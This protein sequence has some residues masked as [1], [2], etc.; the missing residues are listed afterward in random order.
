MDL[1]TITG[2]LLGAACVG[3][4]LVLG[5]SF[6]A[7]VDPVALLIV[8]GG[9]GAA[10]L[11]SAPIRRIFGAHKVSLKA[12]MH[13][14]VSPQEQI[15]RLVNLSEL[16]RREGVLALE[17]ALNEIDDSFLVRGVQLAIDG[18]DP[19]T[20]RSVLETEL[21]VLVERHEAGRS[22]FEQL[23]KYAPAFGMIGTVIGLVAMLANMEDPS[24]IGAGMA[25]ALLTTLYG[26][27]L[28]NLVFL[29]LADKLAAR[30]SEEVLVRSMAIQG[31][32]AIQAGENPRHVD[33]KL[34][35]FL[36]PRARSQ[37]LLSQA[38]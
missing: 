29:P 38:A 35:T 34:R 22:L 12:L 24:A 21:D 36:P 11:V 14:G 32:L 17:G 1:S 3:V 4:A 8:I 13:R 19:E 25:A 31:V 10:T 2:L 27:L 16:A 23:G 30:T 28:A 26:A 5:G 20:I 15:A 18:A 37:G 7:Y 6:G 33:S 9:A